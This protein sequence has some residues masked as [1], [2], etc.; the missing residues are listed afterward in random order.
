MRPKENKIQTRKKNLSKTHRTT[1][2][3]QKNV[4]DAPSDCTLRSQHKIRQRQGEKIDNWQKDLSTP[5]HEDLRRVFAHR[6]RCFIPKRWFRLDLWK[7]QRKNKP[8]WRPFILRQNQSQL[9][10]TPVNPVW[11]SDQEMHVFFFG[12][13]GNPRIPHQLANLVSSR[14]NQAK[15]NEEGS[16]SEKR[17]FASFRNCFFLLEKKNSPANNS[18]REGDSLI[19]TLINKALANGDESYQNSV[20]GKHDIVQSNTRTILFF[21][22]N[23]GCEV[24]TRKRSTLFP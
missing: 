1:S 4:V 22:W 5:V 24:P 18:C 2:N 11:K 19:P 7:K 21:F 23:K 3:V 17:C 13:V 16:K 14:D 6:H 15:Y 8:I 9:Y 12:V 20:N 10:G